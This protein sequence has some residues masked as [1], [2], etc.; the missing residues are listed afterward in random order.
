MKKITTIINYCTND[1]IFLKP[2]ID[3]ALRI[4]HKVIVPFCTHFHDGTKQDRAL[5]LKSVGE[6]PEAEFI[7]FDYCLSLIHISE[8]TRPY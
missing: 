8:P 5:L 1:Y 2:C 6:N 3:A 4:S 7:E